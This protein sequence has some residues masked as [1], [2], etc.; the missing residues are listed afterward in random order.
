MTFERRSRTAPPT[1]IAPLAVALLAV[2]A[3]GP[4]RGEQ[5]AEESASMTEMAGSGDLAK[6][7]FAGGCFWCMEAPF[8]EIDGVVSTTSGYTGGHVEDPSYEQV[9]AGRTGHAEAVQI[10]YDPE[11][12]SY[13]ELLHVFWRNVDPTDAGGQFCDRG[14]Q[15]RTG[16]FVHSEEQQRL[17]ESS[18]E[19]ATRR[20]GKEVVTRIETA[21]P[22]Y[23]AEKYHQDFYD[24]NPIRYK[25]YR[26]GCGRDR[27]LRELW[28]DEAGGGH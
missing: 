26:L 22:F 9:S 6:A 17:A 23:P 12:V 19:E 15:Y 10:A 13:E 8:D 18:K 7:T 14:T 28:G 4:A 1:L 21:G 5:Q 11:K 24:K 3:C 2:L 25:T 20:L 27:R 16:I